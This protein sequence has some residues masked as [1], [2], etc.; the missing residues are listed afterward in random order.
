MLTLLD[1]ERHTTSPQ[2]AE[3][4]VLFRTQIGATIMEVVF[5]GAAAGH[6][7]PVDRPALTLAF[8]VGVMHSA[9]HKIVDASAAARADVAEAAA[10]FLLK[11]LGA[12]LDDAATI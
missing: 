7:A 1:M 5:Q 3:A 11:A 12:S 2:L 9:V 6:F 4:L 10:G 8:M